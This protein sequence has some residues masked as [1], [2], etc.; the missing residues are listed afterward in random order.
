MEYIPPLSICLKSI[1]YYRLLKFSLIPFWFRIRGMHPCCLMLVLSTVLL[2]Q[3]RSAEMCARTCLNPA[4]S[5][6]R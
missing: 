1:T 3:Y 6:L 5:N 4:R 2:L